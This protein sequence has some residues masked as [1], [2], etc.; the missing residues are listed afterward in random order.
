[1]ISAYEFLG[2]K[3]LQKDTE[4]ILKINYPNSNFIQKTSRL[5]RK[6]GGI[7]GIAFMIN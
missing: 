1:M 3:D 4:K 2:I 7:F 5:K 6:I